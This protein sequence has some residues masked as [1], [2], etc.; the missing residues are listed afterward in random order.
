MQRRLSRHTSLIYIIL[1]KTEHCG[2]RKDVF[3]KDSR[4][5]GLAHT[6]HNDGRSMLRYSEP[7]ASSSKNKWYFSKWQKKYIAS[8]RI[9]FHD[10]LVF[11]DAHFFSCY[12]K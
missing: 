9:T 11:K 1:T 10:G 12:E 6:G 8:E 3:S 5:R 7:L 4:T 2:R